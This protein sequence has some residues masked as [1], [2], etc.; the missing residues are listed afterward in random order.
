[1][2]TKPS[3]RMLATRIT[4][5][6]AR[7]VE[8][9]QRV[10]I[11]A[12]KSAKK[13][14]EGNG[15]DGLVKIGLQNFP[16]TRNHEQRYR[17]IYVAFN[18]YRRVNWSEERLTP[19]GN[20]LGIDSG[21]RGGSRSRGSSLESKFPTRNRFSENRLAQLHRDSTGTWCKS[22]SCLASAIGLYS[23]AAS[24]NTGAFHRACADRNGCE[25]RRAENLGSPRDLG[26]LD[27]RGSDSAYGTIGMKRRTV[28]SRGDGGEVGAS[29][30]VHGRFWSFKL[31]SIEDN[32]ALN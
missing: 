6:A 16:R 12:C 29:A 15:K 11:R 23:R 5:R 3:H 22:P 28:G 8:Y 9:R 27:S 4:I 32:S 10:R 31:S 2:V 1:M 18:I 21:S 26:M 19:Q 13:Q 14:T 24:S 7:D 17:R 20:R 30:W 25:Q